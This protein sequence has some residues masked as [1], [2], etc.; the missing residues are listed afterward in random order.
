MT[1]LTFTHSRVSDLS[2]SQKICV[3]KLKR[4]TLGEYL[5]G[6]LPFS[7]ALCLRHG[8]HL[9]ISDPYVTPT[10]SPPA[11]L[12]LLFSQAAPRTQGPQADPE[13]ARRSTH[14]SVWDRLGERG[15]AQDGEEA[16]G[17]EGHG[18]VEVVHAADDPGA[19]PVHGAAPGP[20]GEL[21]Q[22]ADGADRQAAGQPPEG[23]LAEEGPQSPGA[24][25][26]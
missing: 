7:S 26:H 13:H 2:A 1:L 19:P 14:V 16:D 18:E 6:R 23:A 8:G 24:R 20:V 17:E 3:L 22:H 21:G 9:P 4:L 5:I 25:R 15:D 12:Q 11:S 10:P